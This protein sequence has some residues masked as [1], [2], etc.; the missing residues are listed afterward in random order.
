MQ[1]CD[2]QPVE[3]QNIGKLVKTSKR[4][5]FWRFRFHTTCYH[6]S[7]CKLITVIITDST[8]SKKRK[9]EVDG[10]EILVCTWPLQIMSEPLKL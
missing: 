7:S 2:L 8:V 5:F 6:P 3:V 1:V 9:I 10:V 4:K